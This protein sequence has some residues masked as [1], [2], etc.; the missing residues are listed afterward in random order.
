MATVHA[1]TPKA[2]TVERE[3]IADLVVQS[4]LEREVL[5]LL[6]RLDEESQVGALLMLRAVERRVDVAWSPA[7][8]GRRSRDA[9]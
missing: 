4:D 8:R 5:A 7:R 1:L 6:R 9:R 2:D 3:G